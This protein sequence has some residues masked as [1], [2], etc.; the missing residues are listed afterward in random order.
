MASGGTLHI[1]NLAT[2]QWDNV[3]LGIPAKGAACGL[4]LDVNGTATSIVIY[5]GEVEPTA[6]NLGF[7]SRAQIFDVASKTLRQTGLKTGFA[8]GYFGYSGND[9]H[10][11]D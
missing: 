10:V 5:G 8:E 4:E 9:R 6:D 7:N 3:P 1:Q 2:G 11:I